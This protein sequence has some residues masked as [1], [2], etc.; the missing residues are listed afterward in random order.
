MRTPTC[1]TCTCVDCQ[2]T[3]RRLLCWMIVLGAVFGTA[4]GLFLAAQFFPM[5]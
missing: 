3:S 2:R 1:F 4:F 5:P